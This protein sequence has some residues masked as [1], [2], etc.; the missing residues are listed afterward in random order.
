MYA[1][2]REA[3]R[4]HHRSL[5]LALLLGL[6]APPLFACETLSAQ[7]QRAPL[8]AEA[9]PVAREPHPR[10]AALI[11]QA[12][13]RH[14]QADLTGALRLS[15]A[16]LAAD[17]QA[18]RAWQLCAELHIQLGH[19]Q[20]AQQCA[21]RALQWG[22]PEP[23][24]LHVI[25]QALLAQDEPDEALRLWQRYQS[26]HPEEAEGW[27][28]I[29]AISALQGDPEAA[30]R[31]LEHLT[32]LEPQDER[33]WLRLAGLY[34]EM[35]RPLPAARALNT[36]VEADPQR[37][38]HHDARIIALALDGGDL[39]LARRTAQRLIGAEGP[40]NQASL[41]LAALL[42]RR[43]DLFSAAQELEGVLARDP[44]AHEARLMLA[45]I[46]RQVDRFAQALQV[47]QPIAEAEPHSAEAA[48]LRAQL[49]LD[50]GDPQGA[51]E[52]LRARL[53]QH[54]NQPELVRSYADVLRQS[55]QAPAALGLLAQALQR[56]PD[57][58]EIAYEKAL[59]HAQIGEDRHAQALMLRVLKAAPL[60]VG[61]LN[62][63]AFTW[64]E[65]NERLKQAEAF[66]R[67]ALHQHPEDPA[68]LD[69]LAW[70]LYRQRRYAE[71]EPLLR[72]ALHLN[73]QEAELHFHFAAVLRALGQRDAALSA[74]ASALDRAASEAERNKWSRRW[75]QLP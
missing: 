6:C 10:A 67:L 21:Q 50:S 45:R 63:L 58:P 16:A 5:R 54:P 47:L 73:D 23:P 53:A 52:G 11:E 64:A 17:P 30:Q 36:L 33:A 32:R 59:L 75:R 15:E 44:D 65:R 27:R 1:P 46:Y 8:L 35:G 74:L 29:A 70:V 57:H 24:A 68:V 49:L 56:W 4:A 9:A 51:A 62:F 18:W 38:H 72:R 22:A 66:A 69:T 39:A 37:H 26:Q 2:I 25:A 41:T 42:L 13:R 40:P 3:S 43:Q 28:A 20:R 7:P 61:A 19:W 12:E 71:A 34:Q 60:H 14:E 31:A 48:Q 55:G